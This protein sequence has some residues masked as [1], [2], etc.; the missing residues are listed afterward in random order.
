MRYELPP[1]AALD[2]NDIQAS[3]KWKKYKLAWMN[4]AMASELDK[5]SEA[6]RVATL[7]TVIGEEA[8]DVFSTFTDRA[9]QG[10]AAKIEPVLT[11]FSHYVQTCKNKPFER[12]RINSA[13]QSQGNHM[14][15]T[16]QH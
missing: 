16:T 6:V 12:Y 11:K 10:V 13:H 9:E 15:N 8:G 7:P 1:P 3:E 4:Y 5:K 2:I 14:T